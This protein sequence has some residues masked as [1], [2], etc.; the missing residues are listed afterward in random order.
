MK[1]LKI[2][3]FTTDTSNF[4]DKTDDYFK[5]ELVKLSDVEIYFQYKGGNISDILK[6]LNDKPDFI[7][8][9]DF[10]RINRVYGLPT[11][12]DK[13]NIP[14]GILFHDLYRDNDIF[15]EYVEK[16]KI[17]LLYAHYRDGFLSL[18]PQYKDRFIWL[19][20]HVYRP[21]FCKRSI[22]KDIR[23]LMMGSLGK[24]KYP[25]R[26]KMFQR[27]KNV[28]GFVTHK[29]PGYDYS[30]KEN[31]NIFVGE[32]Y[33]KEVA[34]AK[35]FLTCGSIYNYPLGKYFEVPACN[36]LLLA[37]GFPELLDLG[38]IDKKTFVEINEE[39]FEEKAKYYNKYKE[40]RKII[41]RAGHKMVLARHTT[42][43]RVRQFV[44]GLWK[45]LSKNG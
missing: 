27:M 40:E 44:D 2:L 14:K 29:H 35:I 33:A 39:N 31:G 38:F 32:K 9:D 24:K 11:D 42:D 23:F 34:R 6:E 1:K 20:L 16:S 4:V 3:F 43:I 5:K 26:N 22:K 18:Y 37:S 10:E 36:T 7:Y 41:T 19:P 21:I 15:V 30:L 45:F 12:L 8:F 13:V 25:L 28:E 17:D